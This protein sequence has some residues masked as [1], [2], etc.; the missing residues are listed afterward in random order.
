MLEALYDNLI[1]ENRWQYIVDGLFT[2]LQ[3]TFFAVIIGII[4]GFIVAIIRATYE[5]THK[6]KI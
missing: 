5:K 6:L 4:L 2:T 3:I 1:A